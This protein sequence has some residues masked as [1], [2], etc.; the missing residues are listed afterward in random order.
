M[1]KRWPWAMAAWLVL[2]LV[3]LVAGVG[4]WF[5]IVPAVAGMFFAFG[6]FAMS[7]LSR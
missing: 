5:F 2:C 3:L 7:L 1:V 6:L 4:V